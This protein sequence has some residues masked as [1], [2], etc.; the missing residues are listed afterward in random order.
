VSP[1]KRTLVL[2]NEA[3]EGRVLARAIGTGAD[4]A[5]V[6]VVAPALNSRLRHWVSDEDEARRAAQ[7]RLE[8][9]LAGLRDEGID[10][11]GAVGD[12]DPLQ[13]IA[14]TLYVFGADAIVLATPPEDRANWQ[15]RRLAHRARRRFP[16][17]VIQ[18]VAA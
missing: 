1:N 18:L 17:P 9:C 3:A 5:E 13:A 11:H 6:V 15:S 12:A 2:A 4:R 8:R 10:A 7:A 16:L 14:D